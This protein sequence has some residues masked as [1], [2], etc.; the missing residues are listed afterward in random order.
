MDAERFDAL[1]R[2]LSGSG[3]R[4][5]ALG[6]VISGAV[7]PLLTRE[8]AT[9][10]NAATACKK[11][12]GKKKQTC[13]KKARKHNATH[14]DP[15]CLGPGASCAPATGDCCS[16]NCGCTTQDGVTTCSCRVAATSCKLE[17]QP[18]TQTADCCD[19][20]CAC[21]TSRCFCRAEVCLPPG[22]IG[23][24]GHSKCCSKDCFC[25]DTGCIC[26]P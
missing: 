16:G 7:A 25:P 21:T 12:S 24:S 19:G 5:R 17:D 3:S 14:S 22:L 2:F 10:H 15:T 9:A 1:S 4:R 18:C 8:G 11:K 26:S 13:L 6:L 23:C 20:P